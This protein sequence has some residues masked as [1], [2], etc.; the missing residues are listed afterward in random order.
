VTRRFASSLAALVSAAA[1]AL[2]LDC[3]AL[4]DT[5]TPF[6]IK[7]ERRIET[8]GAQMQSAE[9]R[10]QVFRKPPGLVTYQSFAPDSFFRARYPFS[11][12]PDEFFT[13]K[14]GTRV[15][16]TY[17]VTPGPGFLQDDKPLAFHVTMKRHDG[18]II[19]E[20]DHAISVTG[21]RSVEVAGCEFE[22]IRAQRRVTGT[23]NDKPAES[24]TEFWYSPELKTSLFLATQTPNGATQAYKALDIVTEFKPFE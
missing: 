21:R 15:D 22:V 19:G 11:G 8:P 5:Q 16:V 13:S 7:L 20:Q 10:L 6:E 3:A 12:F 2:A 14:E 18:Q 1:P 4:R 9:G 24:Q 23:I 17:S